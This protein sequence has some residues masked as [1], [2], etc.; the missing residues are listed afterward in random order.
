MGSSCQVECSAHFSDPSFN[1]L[2]SIAGLYRAVAADAVITDCQY[3]FPRW[4]KLYRDTAGFTM[5]D[6]VGQCFPG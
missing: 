5:K 3:P 2:Q 1:A 4:R 6:S